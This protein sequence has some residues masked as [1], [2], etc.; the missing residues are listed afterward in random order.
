MAEGFFSCLFIRKTAN[1]KIA[2][3]KK[4]LKKFAH[5]V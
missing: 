4:N 3:K 1:E 2:K 5:Q